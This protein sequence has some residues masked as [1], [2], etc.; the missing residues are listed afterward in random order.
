MASLLLLDVTR[1]FDNILHE[2][3]FYNLKIK[4]ILIRIV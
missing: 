4:G 2:R 3:L 1:A